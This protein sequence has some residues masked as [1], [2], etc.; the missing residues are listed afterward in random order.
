MPSRLDGKPKTYDPKECFCCGRIYT[1]TGNCS[2]RCPECKLTGKRTPKIAGTC[3][4][5]GGILDRNEVRR[6]LACRTRWSKAKLPGIGTGQ[7]NPLGEDSPHYRSGIGLF[8][9]YR[10][11]KCERCSSTKF[12]CVH[13]KDED[14][15]HNSPDNLE[16]LCKRCHQLEHDCT[17][18]IVD[19]S[20]SPEA[21]KRL[22]NFAKNRTDLARDSLGRYK[23][24]K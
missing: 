17:K 2:K 5:C 9:K 19:I 10:K 3:I 21:R 6:C 1:P 8:K 14:R 16:T 7:N 11:D 23:G 20:K 13:H 24:S 18:N 4:I 15:Y 12:L 22:S